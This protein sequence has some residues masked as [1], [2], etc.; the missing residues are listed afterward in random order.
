MLVHA[1]PKTRFLAVIFVGIRPPV[2]AT[3]DGEGMVV[4]GTR[5]TVCWI[6][7]PNARRVNVQH[8]SASAVVNNSFN[9][10]VAPS[11]EYLSGVVGDNVDRKGALVAALVAEE[12]VGHI[13]HDVVSIRLS[14]Y[15]SVDNEV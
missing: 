6:E 11:A 7:D 10:N 4:L 9:F 3:S 12:E 1:D 2:Y 5:K 8:S 13:E 14:T 15:C